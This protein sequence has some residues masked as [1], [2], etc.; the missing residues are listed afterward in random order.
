MKLVKL[1]KMC[2]NEMCSTVH[3]GRHLPH[4]SPVQHGLKQVDAQNY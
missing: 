3:I 2:L 1:I 4:S